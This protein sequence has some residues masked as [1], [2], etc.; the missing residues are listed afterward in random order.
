MS[1][2]PI[3][4]PTCPVCTTPGNAHACVDCTAIDTPVGP[5]FTAVPHGDTRCSAQQP[6]DDPDYGFE[7]GH[8]ASTY[9]SYVRRPPLDVDDFSTHFPIEDDQ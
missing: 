6:Q 9:R 8:S 7:D 4:D 5:L 2:D 3:E 1:D